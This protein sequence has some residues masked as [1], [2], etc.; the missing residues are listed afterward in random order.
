[1]RRGDSRDVIPRMPAAFADGVALFNAG[2]FFEAHEA[3][4]DLLDEVEEDE[5]WD[6]LIALIQVAVGYHKWTSGHPG[7]ARMLGLALEK[8]A[9]FPD[10]AWGIDVGTLRASVARDRTAAEDVATRA[11]TPPRI[12]VIDAPA[13]G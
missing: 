12:Q 4:E 6:L 9:A 13:S 5:R 10:V 7:A 8:L 3:F 2:Q 1:V 11:A